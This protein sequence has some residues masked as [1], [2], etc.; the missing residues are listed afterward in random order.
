MG[1][2]V[3]RGHGRTA[4]VL[5]RVDT[6]R[7]IRIANTVDNLREGAIGTTFGAAVAF[8]VALILSVLL[9]DSVPGVFVAAFFWALWGGGVVLAAAGWADYRDAKRQYEKEFPA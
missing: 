5:N 4:G 6:L 7:Q 9:R 3:T 2:N 8:I 1:V